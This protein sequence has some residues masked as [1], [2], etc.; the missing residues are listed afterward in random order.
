MSYKRTELMME[1]CA[2]LGRRLRIAGTGPEEERLKKLAATADV[3][4]LGELT[5][6]ALWREYA[7]VPGTA[8]CG[9]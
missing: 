3:E 1:A 8:V 9:G 4:F 7:G 2:R 5:T 6:E